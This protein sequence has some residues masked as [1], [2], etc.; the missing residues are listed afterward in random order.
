MD[1]DQLN[2]GVLQALH[3]SEFELTQS[4]ECGIESFDFHLEAG[5]LS[6]LDM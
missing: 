4:R 2:G 5:L 3:I 1:G 6:V